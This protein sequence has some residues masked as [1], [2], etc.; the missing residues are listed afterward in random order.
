[1]NGSRPIEKSLDAVAAAGIVSIRDDAPWAKVEMQRGQYRIPEAWDRMVDAANER[2]ISVL[3]ILDYGNP[4]YEGGDKPRSKESIDAFVRYA[5]FVVEHFKGRV[6]SYEIWNEWS[7][8]VG[9]TSPGSADDYVNL[10]RRVYPAVKK[11]DPSAKILVGAVTTQDMERSF[12]KEIIRLGA[13][14]YSDGLSIHPYVQCQR[15]PRPADW[16]DWMRKVESDLVSRTGKA[17][18]LYVTEMGWPSFSGRCGV[19]EVTQ[20]RYLSE[21]FSL[22]RSMPFIQGIWWYDLQDDCADPM[23]QECR[24]GLLRQDYTP[25]PA[26]QAMKLSTSH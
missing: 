21:L 24:F 14:D 22:A 23:N 18:P 9:H 10:I 8:T 3:L 11:V 19:D 26:Y 12:F 25:K 17:V 6:T 15:S 1:M 7:T 5:R 20:A 13:M 2:H 16:A 4:F